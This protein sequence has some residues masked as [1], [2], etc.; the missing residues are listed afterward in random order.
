MIRYSERA[1]SVVAVA[2]ALDESGNIVNST[3]VFEFEGHC[4]DEHVHHMVDEALKND[5]YRRSTVSIKHTVRMYELPIE[6]FKELA[7][8]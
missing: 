1:T 3:V 5:G 6:R 4:S 7:E 2:A 8:R